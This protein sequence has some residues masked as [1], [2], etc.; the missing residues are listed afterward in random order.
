MYILHSSFLTS[1]VTERYAYRQL[2]SVVKRFRDQLSK[3][4][5]CKNCLECAVHI[6]E[7]SASIGWSVSTATILRENV[8]WNWTWRLHA[9]PAEKRCGWRTSL[10]NGNVSWNDT[11]KGRQAPR[12]REKSTRGTEDNSLRLRRRVLW[13]RL[14]VCSNTTDGI[15]SGYCFI[16]I[17]SRPEKG[18]VIRFLDMSR[19]LRWWNAPHMCQLNC[20]GRILAGERN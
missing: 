8:F 18:D 13:P 4:A 19:A 7:E 11:D 12:G 15:P 9:V 5:L 14:C 2:L 1:H 17:I 10:T 3:V 20:L 6:D 16:V